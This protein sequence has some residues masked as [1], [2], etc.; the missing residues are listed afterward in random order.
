MYKKCSKCATVKPL[1]AYHKDKARYDGVC[2]YC[3]P[4]ESK[5]NKERYYKYIDKER[6]RSKKYRKLNPEKCR[7]ANDKWVRNN[8][9]KRKATYRRFRERHGQKRRDYQNRKQKEYKLQR[10][11]TLIAKLGGKCVICGYNK[12][13]SALDLHHLVPKKKAYWCDYMK[14][15]F[16]LSQVIL[17]CANC[18]RAV[19]WENLKVVNND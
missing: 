16:D 17:L 3:K 10:R 7:E 13:L 18:H 1:S 14:K 5:R 11:K 19:T 8:P 2:V 9:E 15:D 6:A 4:C 12:Y